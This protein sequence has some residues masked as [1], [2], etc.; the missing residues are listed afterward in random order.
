MANDNQPDTMTVHVPVEVPADAHP[1][2]IHAVMSHVHN[3]AKDQVSQALPVLGREVGAAG[4]TI[5]SLPKALYQAASAP[6]TPEES[7]R[8]G[9]GFESKIGPTGRLIDRTTVQ[10]LVN[11]IDDYKNGR[12]SWDDVLSVAPEALGGA[13]GAVVTGKAAT[14][15]GKAAGVLG[16]NKSP[17]QETAD[18][19]PDVSYRQK[20]RGENGNYLKPMPKGITRTNRLQ[21]L[22]ENIHPD[23]K[24]DIARHELAHYDYAAQAGHPTEDMFMRIGHSYDR[25]MPENAFSTGQTGTSNAFWKNFM[26][27]AKTPEARSAAATKY[28]K[29]LYAPTVVEELQG[30]PK[31]RIPVI[32]GNDDLKAQTFMRTKMGLSP[33]EIKSTRADVLNQ[34]RDE[35]TPKTMKQYTHAANQIVDNHYGQYVSPWAVDHYLDGGTHEA[36]ADRLAEEDAPYKT[37]S[38]EGVGGFQLPTD[39]PVNILRGI[40]GRE[41]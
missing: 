6:E 21:W 11:A 19:Q 40:L 39:D 29:V 25:S 23:A 26:N 18:D 34:L 12:V 3:Y 36:I 20:E 16:E 24:V 15:L 30:T 17:V 38:G 10:P 4:Q 1:S 14:S 2:A 28:L 9:K 22:D 31:E 41:K 37:E 27:A 32:A 5:A 13:S 33:E 35:I 8:Y 7:A